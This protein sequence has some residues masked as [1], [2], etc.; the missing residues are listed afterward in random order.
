MKYRPLGNT[1][2]NVSEIT[3][4]TM[5]WGQ[6]NSEADAHA[7]LDLGNRTWRES[8]RYR[9]NVSGPTQGRT[10]GL[11]ERYLGNLAQAGGHREK[12]LVATKAAGPARMPHQPR[13]VRDGI[14]HL[15]RKGLTEA[16][17]LSLERLQTDY[18]D[19]YQLHWPDRP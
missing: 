11:T 8:D 7:Q 14:N 1:S 17:N 9:R 5:T 12:V 18:V 4:G 2:I 16:L 15:D 19:L 3:L 6:Q 10:Q 13:H